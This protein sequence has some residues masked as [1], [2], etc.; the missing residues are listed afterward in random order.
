MACLSIVRGEDGPVTVLANP[1]F[2]TLLTSTEFVFEVFEV[3]AAG[4][5]PL[6][7]Q[8]VLLYVEETFWARLEALDRVTSTHPGLGL[9]RDKPTLRAR[10]TVFGDTLHSDREAHARD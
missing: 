6:L 7:G 5:R 2:P 3:D 10:W 1:I 9:L 4:L 8:T